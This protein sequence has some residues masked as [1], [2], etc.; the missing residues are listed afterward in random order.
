MDEMTW[1]L[2]CLFVLLLAALVRLYALELNPL[3]HDEGVNGFFLIKLINTGGYQY[4]PANY[5]GPTLYYFALVSAKL[6]KLVG[7]GLSIYAIRIV[8]V[9]FGVATIWLILCLRR[10]L[11]AEGALMAAALLAL[12]P[13]AVYMSRYFIHESLFVFLTLAIIVASLR[14]YE[15]ANPIFLMLASL[16]AALLFATKETAMISAGVMLI[17]L[18]STTLYVRLRR[19][20]AGRS[21]RQ[22]KR[23]GRETKPDALGETLARF[24]GPTGIAISALAALALFVVVYLLFYSSFLTYAQGISDSLKTFEIW[25]K[26]GKKDH[27]HEW[28]TYLLWLRQEEAPLLAL[29]AAGVTLALL[30]ARNSFA[31]FAAA[32][33]IGIIAAYSLIPYKTP[34]LTLN[35]IVPLAIIGGYAVGLLYRWAADDLAQRLLVLALAAAALFICGYQMI[36]LNFKHYDEE[37]YVYPYAHTVR[38]FLPLVERL[39]R[40]AAIAGTGT[41]TPINVASPEYWPLPWYLRDYTRVGYG[42]RIAGADEPLVI[43]SEEQEFELESALGDRYRRVDSY[44]LRPGVNLVLYARRDLAER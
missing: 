21:A 32:W 28:Y 22:K 12:S 20:A 18:A 8:P 36:E 16:S 41:Q 6:F 13:G 39:D 2:A 25:A 33:A 43:C 15:S 34:W 27:I 17:A 23:R 14:Y 10:R 1:R 31:V 7:A 40:F 3:H 29:G 19:G 44:T 9:A 42:G 11:S 35:F 38:Q 24:D 5:H 26:T 30:R 4:D 37:R